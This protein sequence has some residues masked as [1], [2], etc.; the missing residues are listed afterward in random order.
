MTVEMLSMQVTKDL[1]HVLTITFLLVLFLQVRHLAL[2]RSDGFVPKGLLSI[3]L[4]ENFDELSAEEQLEA[5]K[6]RA[7]QFLYKLYDIT[8][9]KKC[10]DI[11]ATLQFKYSL[12]GQSRAFRALSSPTM[13]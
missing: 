2:I 6:L 12:A 5:K 10:L 4:P 3:G 11:A 13:N 9:I 1:R 7:A 8:T